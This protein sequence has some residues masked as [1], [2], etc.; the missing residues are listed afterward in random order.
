MA[1]ER[2]PEAAFETLSEGIGRRDL[3]LAATAIGA[4]SI[5]PA[6]TLSPGVE[7][8]VAAGGDGPGPRV[9][10]SGTGRRVGHYVTSRPETVRW[11]YLPN[12]DAGPV[13]TV[14]SGTLVTFDTVS[15]EG[16]LEDQGRDPVEYF[17]GKGVRKRDI[18][19]DARAI[20][21]S[22]VE[23]DF[24][25]DGP[26]IVTG[27]IDVIGAAP[28][29]VLRVDVVGL[30][31]RAPYGVISNRHGKGALPGEYPQTPPPDPNASPEH[32]ELYHN[33][34]V[35]TPVRTIRKRFRGVLPVSGRMRAEFPIDP[36]MGIMGV[37]LDTSEK[38]NSVPPTPAGGN[39]DIRDL[40]VGSKL[41]LPVFVPGAKFF[42]GDPHYRQGDGEVALTALEAPLRGTFRLTLLKKGS[43]AIPG[44]RERTSDAVRG[45]RR[46]LAAGGAQRRP[47]RG[48][49]AGGPRGNRVPARRARDV[50]RGCLRLHERGDRLRREP[51]GRQDEG[52]TRPHPQGP[53]RQASVGDERQRR[54]PKFV[55]YVPPRTPERPGMPCTMPSPTSRKLPV[56]M[57]ALCG[58][59]FI[60]ARIMLRGLEVGPSP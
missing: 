29:D 28:G 30:V 24:A 57:F 55:V 58:V 20:A 11:G 19:R 37:A 4:G 34:S 38:V 15:H 8:A 52:R 5:A 23:H 42:V 13:R 51:G 47:R 27:P 26:H 9:L 59:L 21:D 44:N 14:R 50:P 3:L 46:L 32:P 6:W 54:R 16:I 10:Q 31:P 45:E 35:F 36:F 17:T 22:E 41:Y 25:N 18:L 60:H 33:V 40:T 7:D 56:R 39:L 49:E 48:D 1:E 53:L 12:R 43:R 2:H